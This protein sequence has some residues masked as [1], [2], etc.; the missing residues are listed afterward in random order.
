MILLELVMKVALI[1][2]NEKKLTDFPNSWGEL[3]LK[4]TRM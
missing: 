4:V 2:V 1:P 3:V